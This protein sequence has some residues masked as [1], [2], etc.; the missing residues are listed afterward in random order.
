MEHALA[1]S[2]N[3][4]LKVYNLRLY[5]AKLSITIVIYIVNNNCLYTIAYG[6]KRRSGK[7]LLLL[8]EKHF[9]AE[10]LLMRLILLEGFS[11][12]NKCFTIL[13]YAHFYRSLLRFCQLTAHEAKGL[14]YM[15]NTANLDSYRLCHQDKRIT[16]SSR[17]AFYCCMDDIKRP[18]R[19]EVQFYKAMLTIHSNIS[20]E[21]I[22]NDQ[23]EAVL[24]LRCL[25]GDIESQFY[26][27]FGMDIT[28][29]RTVFARCIN[30]LIPTDLEPSVCLLDEWFSL[31]LA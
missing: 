3:M 5:R 13:G 7:P 21:A 17:I 8:Y 30:N 12:T 28:D 26:K 31:S 6:N 4:N 14:T 11:M 18:Y 22:T 1:N 20:F 23:R 27:S 9:G 15:L 16:E 19:T 25:M 10:L 2:T 24:F 29:P